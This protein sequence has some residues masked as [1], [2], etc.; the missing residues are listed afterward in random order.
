MN[1][2]RKGRSLLP[3]LLLGVAV[4]LSGCKE[5]TNN[6]ANNA[7]S[8]PPAATTQVAQPAAEPAKQPAAAPTK[9]MNG[10]VS[11]K[12]NFY[13]VFDGSGSMR[14]CPPATASQRN[15]KSKIAAGKDAL[16]AMV[17][18]LPDDVNLGLYVFDLSGDREV[19]PL[20]PNNK[21]RF[22]AAVDAVRAENGTPLGEAIQTGARV[23][24]AQYEKQLGYG[25]FRL[26]VVTDG[27]ANGR[28]P[29]ATAVKDA[30][31]AKIPIFTIGFGIGNTHELRRYSV[32][33]WAADTESQ[34]KQALLE[35]V[36][37]LDSPD[38][39]AVPQK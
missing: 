22:L 15:C 30:N 38:E 36:S 3:V 24:A 34:V 21:A 32:Q 6:S 20:G 10:V 7:P 16:R 37:E 14:D 35:A 25:E 4:A 11:T 1:F 39:P 31:A 29:L 2:F 12:K 5:E 26:V 33:Y 9:V 28:I 13:V 27:D 8:S 23:L 17:A 18:A 19:V